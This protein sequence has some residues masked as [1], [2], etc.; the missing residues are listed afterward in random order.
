MAKIQRSKRPKLTYR[1]VEN[2]VFL[3]TGIP[4]EMV[5]AA[6]SS[7][8]EIIQESLIGQVEVP[9]YKLGYFTIKQ[10]KPKQMKQ[11]FAIASNYG[12]MMD[13]DGYQKPIFRVNSYFAHNM[14][15]ATLWKFGEENPMLELFDWDDGMDDEEE[16]DN[17]ES[18]GF[19]D[20]DEVDEDGTDE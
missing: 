16:N 13:L 19:D 9:L 8:C 20:D 6:I 14:K 2:Q 3:R 11:Y 5:R 12:E 15:E 4:R 17:V 18:D 10:M 1:E 7:Y